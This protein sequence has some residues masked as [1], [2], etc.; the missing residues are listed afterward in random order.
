MMSGSGSLDY[1]PRQT[2][3]YTRTTVGT[4][5]IVVPR[6]SLRLHHKGF[7]EEDR[8]CSVNIAVMLLEHT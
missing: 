1:T 4:M 8:H 7:L 5:D 2:H 3:T 6:Q